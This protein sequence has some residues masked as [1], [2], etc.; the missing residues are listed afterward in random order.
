M[1]ELDNPTVRRKFRI[2]LVFCSPKHVHH[3]R[4]QQ[5]ERL[6]R[7]ALA[8]A[9]Q[10]EFFDFKVLPSATIDDLAEALL[11]D[12]YHIV[13]F[14]GHAD[15]LHH[16]RQNILEKFKESF[17]AS[18]MEKIYKDSA[19]LA[20]VNG[21]A[22]DAANCIESAVR[23][24]ATQ[25]GGV[26][27]TQSMRVSSLPQALPAVAQNS[28][29]CEKALCRRGNH[30]VKLDMN[31][32]VNVS[33]KEKDTMKISMNCTELLG[34]GVGSLAFEDEE[35]RPHFI[36]PKKFADLLAANAPPLQCVVLNACGSSLAG[37]ILHNKLPFTVCT[38]GSLSDQ[39]ALRWSSGFYSAI[40]AGHGIERAYIEGCQRVALH[41]PPKRTASSN[42]KESANRE[43][44]SNNSENEA[45]LSGS[46]I[47]LHNKELTHAWR[48][49]DTPVLLGLREENRRLRLE[50]Q[51]MEKMIHDGMRLLVHKEKELREL[52]GQNG[53]V[54]QTISNSEIV[55]KLQEKKVSP[56]MD[57]DASIEILDIN[58]KRMVKENY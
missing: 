4:L 35:G 55:S 22:T 52:K 29:P 1:F 6:I 10:R 49:S 38:S 12:D 15:I 42:E 16:V 3:L 31:V 27:A 26:D 25:V 24:T 34:S 21:A 30:N 37:S 57:F 53:E 44:D 54:Q 50:K 56:S 41:A 2:L 51:K 36:D 43:M 28:E 9:P 18:A 23:H 17:G 14:S 33:D 7:K 11:A 46:T 13:H 39:D 32:T 8:R 5:E 20:A 48:Q 47:L 19:A 45:V 40:G 58:A